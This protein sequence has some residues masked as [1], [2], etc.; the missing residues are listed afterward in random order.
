MKQ[1]Q[2]VTLLPVVLFSNNAQRG[3]NLSNRSSSFHTV[4]E[5]H[6]SKKNR[7]FSLR[8]APQKTPWK[9]PQ[10]QIS[11]T[12]DNWRKLWS[13]TKNQIEKEVPSTPLQSRMKKFWASGLSDSWHDGSRSHCLANADLMD[14]RQELQSN[15]QGDSKL[16]H[17]PPRASTATLWV[18][19]TAL[20]WKN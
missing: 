7:Q 6:G 11:L 5:L 13:N 3:G 4:Q 14:N 15:G 16:T 8:K 12:L 10:I 17:Y 2:A 18:I 1:R 20:G 9:P 19:P